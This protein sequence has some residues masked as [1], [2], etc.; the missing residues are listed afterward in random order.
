MENI[1]FKR[2]SL[3]TI[4]VI[5]IVSVTMVLIVVIDFFL[6][7]GF[8]QLNYDNYVKASEKIVEENAGIIS[9]KINSIVELLSYI[10]KENI[11]QKSDSKKVLTDLSNMQKVLGGQIAYCQFTDTLGITTET[12]NNKT[13]NLEENPR[14]YQGMKFMDKYFVSDREVNL[15]DNKKEVFYISVPYSEGERVYGYLSAAIDASEI[16]SIISKIETSEIGNVCILKQDSIQQSIATINNN[17]NYDKIKNFDLIE[18][19][20]KSDLT[21]GKQEIK[22]T[23]TGIEYT[24]IFHHINL[25]RW[26]LVMFENK[27]FIDSQ[28]AKLRNYFIWSNIGV[29]LITFIVFYF[30]VKA[31]VVVPMRKLQR[32]VKEFADGIMYNA[33]EFANE[34]KDEIGEFSQNVSK[35]ANQLISTLSEI[36]KHTDKITKNS[37]ELND[38]ADLIY[39]RAGDQ[40]SAVEEISATIEQMTS[41]ITQ[42][43]S[44]AENT[45][46]NSDSIA[47]DINAVLSASDKTLESIKMIIEKIKIINDIAKKTDLLAVNA[48][49]EASRSGD[50]GK[51][52]STVASEI[53]KLAERCKTASAQIDEASNETLSI[54][55]KSTML[56]ENITPRIKDNAEKVSEIA[57]ACAEQKNGAGQINN[58]IQQLTQISVENSDLSEILATKADNFNKYANDLLKSIHFFKLKDTKQAQIDNITNLIQEHSDKIAV[59]REE[60]QKKEDSMFE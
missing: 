45:K 17:I 43:A 34:S 38:S 3:L 16:D 35:M 40:S 10:S 20:F 18:S 5:R 60:L 48:A 29:L 37:R 6:L 56:I 53:K 59:L 19:N 15:N 9:Q 11:I 22:N 47:N 46:E 31:K 41:S 24:S 49:V 7:T 58:A 28:R 12:I 33:S 44:N 23:E 52:F 30:A 50:N 42:T 21:N 4:L 57:V 54:T 32:T 2:N 51:G 14:F 55:E 1:V 25:T 39:K 27:S 26:Y 8:K 36:K 13:I